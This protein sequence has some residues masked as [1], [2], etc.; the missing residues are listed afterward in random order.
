MCSDSRFTEHS[1]ASFTTPQLYSYPTLSAISVW[2]EER[3]I[4]HKMLAN[5]KNNPNGR[6]ACKSEDDDLP[7]PVNSRRSIK[8]STQAVNFC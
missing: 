4:T 5:E 3:P 2:L 1:K 8:R 7:S 6:N